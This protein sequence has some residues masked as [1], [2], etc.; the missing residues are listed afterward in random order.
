VKYK[1]IIEELKATVDS[2]QKKGVT[3]DALTSTI[4]TLEKH[5][6][7]ISALEENIDAVRSEI[8]TP[9]LK[10]L[11]MGQILSK[12]SLRIGIIGACIGALG[13]PSLTIT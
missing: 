2:L 9:V 11:G 1:D 10:E 8:T 3:V 12:T 4:Q 13:V 6:D 7:D 5:A